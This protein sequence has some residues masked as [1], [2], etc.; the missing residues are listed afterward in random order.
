MALLRLAT[1][2]A[3]VERYKGL[4]RALFQDRKDGCVGEARYRKV[5]L[6][7]GIES[8]VGN[9]KICHGIA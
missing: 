4:R 7:D 9:E 8:V 6:N 2:V 5:R 3:Q 1:D